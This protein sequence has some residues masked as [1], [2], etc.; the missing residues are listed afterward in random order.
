MS[1]TR[2]TR[3]K[4]FKTAGTAGLALAAVEMLPDV[5]ATES[6]QVASVR[7][8]GQKNV[9]LTNA[10]LIDSVRPEPQLKATVVVQD[11]KITRVGSGQPTLT[12]RRDAAVIDL[13]GAWLL[14]GLCDAHAHFISPLQA[15]PGETVIDRYLR[16]GSG[17]MEA[18]KV[19]VTSARVVGAPDF[20]DIA[21]RKAFARGTFLGPRLFAGGHTIVPTAGH[22]SGYG[23]G[24][25]V[26]ADGPIEVR[27][28]VREQIQA[29]VDLIKIVMTGGVFGLR[30]DSLDNNEFLQDEIDAAFET[31]HQRGYK[32]SAH[33]GNAEA[34][35]MAARAGAHSIE[36][37]YVLDEEAIQLMVK[38]KTI[39]VPTLCVTFLTDEAAESEY[40]KQWTTRWPMPANL[41]ER[42]NQRRSVHVEAFKAA[43]AAGVRIASG[44]DHS[45][46]SETAFLE[47]E[48]L[49]RCG[50]RP[51]QAI[52]AATRVSADAATAEKELGTVE[53]GKL[54]DLLVVRG[55]PLSS[56]HNLR[57]TLMVFKEGELVV[58]NR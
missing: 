57:Q 15:P 7:D 20:C 5:F 21:W 31:A 19:G 16:F 23:Y 1:A 30:W 18:L 11:G 3:R 22:G 35:K 4:F 53:P 27:R 28:A 38:H 24:Q 26:V 46:L 10:S 50:M 45:P 12:E 48:L 32:V 40:E 42:A 58:D 2:F 55:S 6:R 13:G 43:L 34:V 54:A 39:Y 25:K 41:Q 51:M 29:D 49:V 9:I 37:G 8:P 33:A 47:I 56:I 52:I 44:A 17:A 14:P 36:H